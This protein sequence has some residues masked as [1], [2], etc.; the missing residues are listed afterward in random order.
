M[1]PLPLVEKA[2]RMAIEEMLP[3]VST[4]NVSQREMDEFCSYYRRIA[5]CDVLTTGQP[6]GFFENLRKSATAYLR[7]LESSAEQSLRL[8]WS[9]PL[10]DALACGDFD[11]ARRIGR[12]SPTQLRSELEYEEDFL[13]VGFVIA[14]IS[15]DGAQEARNALLGRYETLLDGADD[16]RFSVCSALSN[17]DAPRFNAALLQLVAS[18]EASMLRKQEAAALPADDAA[19][20]LRV[21]VE[22]LA[23]VRLAEAAGLATEPEYL[24]IPATI[25]PLPSSSGDDRAPHDR[26]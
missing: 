15:T 26:P 23:L 24:S 17:G 21:S 18:D 6:V 20:F 16:A 14:S 19:T 12:R 5:I 25:R 2:S 8:A 3:R 22:G 7:Y 10:F 9:K 13:Y 1:N 4:T 11:L